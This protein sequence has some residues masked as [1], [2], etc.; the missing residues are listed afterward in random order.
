[1]LQ[2]RFFMI[3]SWAEEGDNLESDLSI[4]PPLLRVDLDI[5]LS[6]H[7]PSISHGREGGLNAH[8]RLPLAARGFFLPH[9]LPIS[10]EI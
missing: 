5:K 7:H 6:G 9:F 10:Y 3:L 8:R 2:F 4:Y 1:M